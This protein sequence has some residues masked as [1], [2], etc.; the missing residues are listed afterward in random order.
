M[1]I[2]KGKSKISYLLI[3]LISLI[4][5]SGCKGS[6]NTQSYNLKNTEKSFPITITDDLGRKV[7]LKAEPKRII[8]LAPSNTEILFALGLGDRVVGDTTFCD[9]PE[10]AKHCNKIGGFED[11]SLE[12]IVALKPDLI[13][14]TGMH[15]QIIYDL[16]ETGLT[17]LILKP[18]S[19]DGI[20][21]NILLVGKATGMEKKAVELNKSLENRVSA[22]KNKVGTVPKDQRPTVYYEMW[23]EPL[24]SIGKGS[25]IGQLI[26][27]AGGKS[28]TD[29][30]AEEYPQVSDEIIIEKNPQVMF[31]SYGH[32]NKEVTPEGV[33]ARKGWSEISFVKTKRI[34]T[35]DNDLL[36]LPGPRIVDGLEKIA[37]YL[38]PSLFK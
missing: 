27:I 22:V 38:Y 28:I 16:E 37:E 31:N 19:I 12:K 1:R 2:S 5:L 20:F 3:L 35:I 23:D 10:E 36:T 13:L 34:Y 26:N 33:A 15:Q 4:A 25:L 18:H 32:E 24:M 17:V 9:Y 6:A 14:G 8:S 30:C 7:S 29:D 21:N 11:P